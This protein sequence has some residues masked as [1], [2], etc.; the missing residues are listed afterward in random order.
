MVSRALEKY[1]RI[2]AKK[3]QPIARLISGKNVD[4]AN[5]VLLNANKKGALILKS[6]LQSAISN[7]KRMPDKKVSVEDLYISRIEVN[8][9]PSLKR[10]RAMTMGRAGSIR[11]R[12]S[13]VIMEL[14]EQKKEKKIKEPKTKK[15]IKK[16]AV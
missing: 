14:D 10:Y 8:Q 15:E 13:H 2:S 5:Y 4:E 11:K 12:T 16:R 9:G 6:V 7:A 1:L 3:L